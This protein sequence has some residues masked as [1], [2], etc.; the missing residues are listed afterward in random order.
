MVATGAAGIGSEHSDLDN[1]RVWL[2]ETSALVVRVI[3][4]L[5]FFRLGF[6][7]KIYEGLEL[8]KQIS[9]NIG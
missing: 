9:R 6:A 8:E 5:L 2:V 3:A 4:K 1:L 7:R